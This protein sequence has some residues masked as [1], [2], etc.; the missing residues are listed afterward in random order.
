[1]TAT[2]F[3]G[4]LRAGQQPADV[5]DPLEA[6]VRQDAALIVVCEDTQRYADPNAVS[7]LFRE[8]Q[9]LVDRLLSDPDFEIV[10]RFRIEPFP[11]V[12]LQRRSLAIADDPRYQEDR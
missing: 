7:V 10:H 11:L 2:A 6:Q 3:E 5:L 12:V 9:P 4:P 1:M 8:G